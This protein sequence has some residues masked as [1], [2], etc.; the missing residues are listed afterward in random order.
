MKRKIL[1]CWSGGKDSAL[2]LYR[3]LKDNKY[4]VVSL[5][6]T[7]NREYQRVSMHGVR[8]SLLEL[9]AE[10]IGIPLEKIYLEKESTNEEYEKRMEEALLKFKALGV[11]EVAFGDIFLE[12][13][14]KY[15]EDNLAKAGM[16][17]IFPLWKEDTES[18]IEEF[19]GIGFKTVI[20]CV[21]N[22]FLDDSFAGK[23]ISEK[24]INEIPSNVDCCGEN[25][26]FHTFAF[27]GPLFKKE[28]KFILGEKVI[29][30][31]EVKQMKDDREEIEQKSYCFIDILPLLSTES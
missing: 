4:E 17:G 27:E 11:R 25:G 18:L 26:E 13:L 10:S 22:D 30:N 7:V 16:K 5:L 2:A 14:K 21:N 9:Q 28:I 20:C 8:E 3:V 1:F 15:R 24:F 29:K 31:Y 19:I 12:D 23:V 6:T